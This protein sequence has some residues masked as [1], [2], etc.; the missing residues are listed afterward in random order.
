MAE[1]IIQWTDYT[2][3]IATG[4]TKVDKDCKYCYMYR[5]SLKATRYNPTTV[6]RTKQ[7]FNYPLTIKKGTESKVWHGRPLVFASSLTDFF[8]PDIDS[9]RNEAW[10]IIRNSP[11]L[12]FQ[13]LTK[14]PERIAEQ[15]PPDL[16]Q[17]DN[18]WF[19]TSIGHMEGKQRVIDLGMLEFDGIKFLSIEPMHGPIDFNKI[20]LDGFGV[21]F[22]M[23]QKFDWV[24]IG[25]ESG[26][27]NGFY[28]YR[29]CKVE[30]FEKIILQ[31]KRWQVPVFVKQLGTYLSK[32]L[33]MSDRHGA[34]INDFPEQLR[35]REFPAGLAI[36]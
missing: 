27:E 32:Q 4:C 13:I 3:N 8:H 35:I 9:Y 2:W 5:G 14:R 18:I 22:S 26:N 31:C 25:G 16:M 6:K 12:I 15:T 36:K 23:L 34:N 7:A 28:K 10:E 33:K 30:W 17:A 1:S 19:G 21:H 11:H 24:I 20:Y 29:E